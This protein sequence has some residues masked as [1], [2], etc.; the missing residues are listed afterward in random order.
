MFRHVPAGILGA[1]AVELVDGHGF[2]KI[3]HIYLF[4]LTGGAELRRHHVQGNIH[5]GNDPRITLADTRCFD[6]Y[7]VISRHFHRI[8][9]IRQV[10]RDLRCR[11]TGGKG[12]HEYRFMINRV[13]TDTVAQQRAAGFP[14]GRIDREH[15]NSQAVQAV[16]A[17][18]QD[19]FIGERGF[20]GAAR[21]GNTQHGRIPAVPGRLAAG[22]FHLV[23]GIPVVFNCADHPGQGYF[24]S[25]SQLLRR[26]GTH[27]T[28]IKAAGFQHVVYHSL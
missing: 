9:D 6:D 19:D 23:R 18:P 27:T 5:Q 25:V 4:Q 24:I 3:Q 26:N 13:H 14:A 2:G 22:R 10:F 15:G 1:L 17:K 21:S 12:T 28:N 16:Q 7:Q 20:A 8:Y 11:R